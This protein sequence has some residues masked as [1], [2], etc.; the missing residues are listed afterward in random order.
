MNR[1]SYLYFILGIVLIISI[2]ILT[3]VIVRF[4]EHYR[5]TLKQV[6]FTIRVAE[7]SFHDVDNIIEVFSSRL[8][9]VEQFLNELRKT[10][11]NLEVINDKFSNIISVAQKFPSGLASSLFLLN[12]LD[13]VNGL[14]R[15][16]NIQENNEELNSMLK[17]FLKGAVVGGLAVAFLTPKTGEEMREYAGEKLDE[18]KEKAKN[19]DIDEVRQTLYDKIDDL[20]HFIQ[21]AS[22]D[23]IIDK[24]FEEIK[25]L[26]MKLME[27]LPGNQDKT[28]EV[29]EKQ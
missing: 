17:D 29:I 28:P 27:Y 24:V 20:K 2:I 9:D 21:N 15:L 6:D 10:G 13:V 25:K 26:Y 1:L 22:K 16:F 3:F 23:D 19:I 14:Q 18:L 4:F 11:Q 12:R 5:N 8:T 7:N